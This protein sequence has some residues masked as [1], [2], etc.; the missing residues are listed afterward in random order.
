LP[1]PTPHTVLAMKFARSG[2]VGLAVSTIVCAVFE[3][4]AEEI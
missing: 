2:H 4:L 3:N 1:K